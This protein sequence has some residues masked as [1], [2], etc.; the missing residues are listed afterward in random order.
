MTYGSRFS[1]LGSRVQVHNSLLRVIPA[2]A[3][4]LT[5]QMNAPEPPIDPIRRCTIEVA[6]ENGAAALCDGEAA[7]W[8][9]IRNQRRGHRDQRRRAPGKSLKECQEGSVRDVVRRLAFMHSQEGCPQVG[10]P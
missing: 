9:A 1:V 5:R 2:P 3:D 7:I 10:V 4:R 8:N 6:V